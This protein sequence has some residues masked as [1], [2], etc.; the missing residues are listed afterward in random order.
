MAATAAQIEGQTISP[1]QGFVNGMWEKEINIRD[2][3]QQNY[4]PYHGDERF[5]ALATKR[6]Q[7]LWQK[8]E[9]LFV[10]ERRKGVVDAYTSDIR[11]CRSSHIPRYVL[12]ARSR[13]RILD[14]FANIARFAA[15]LG[16]IERVEV[17]P[18]HQMGRYKWAKLGMRYALDN[19]EPP[20]IEATEKAVRIF[21]EQGLTAH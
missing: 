2:F 5:L 13:E 4:T 8:L 1:W 7:T 14:A 10:E 6:T 17:L 21:K 19:A 18:F 9:A 3:I 15:D 12:R 11:R 20:T 16:N